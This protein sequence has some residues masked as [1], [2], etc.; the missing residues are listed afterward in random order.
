MK[1]RNLIVMRAGD[2]SLHPTWLKAETGE[3]NWDLHIS[4]FADR[5][6]H[7]YGALP[8][9]VTVSLEKGAKA[10]GLQTCFDNHPGLTD[11][12]QSVMVADD[13]IQLTRGTWSEMFDIFEQSGAVLGQASLD[14]R[15]F[16]SH[17]VTI[18]R[19]GLLYRETNFVEIMS[20]VF[21]GN[22]LQ[23]FL[24]KFTVS[25]TSWGLDMIMSHRAGQSGGKIVIIDQIMM[26]HTRAVGAL[27]GNYEGVDVRKDFHEA[28]A[29]EGMKKVWPRTLRGIRPD[30]RR[31]PG[32]LLNFPPISAP[33]YGLLVRLL[34]VKVIQN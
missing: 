31:T 22:F 5:W 23:Q 21:E 18:N 13:D 28:L 20:P 24:T 4:Y 9:G 16:Y 33:L 34:R 3:R 29:K 2:S 19:R 17:D 25:K 8:D 14:P 30:G 32:W 27:T 7:P 11:G 26:L 6:P 1:R 15:S 12:Y 10:I